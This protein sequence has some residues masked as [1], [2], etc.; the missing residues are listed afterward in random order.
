V[1]V[2]PNVKVS[3][4]H[5]IAIKHLYNHTKSHSGDFHSFYINE[6][7]LLTKEPSVLLLRN[8]KTSNYTS[9]TIDPGRQQHM[10]EEGRKLN[11]E[12]DGKQWCTL[13]ESWNDVTAV[14]VFQHFQELG[15]LLK[16]DGKYGKY[17]QEHNWTSPT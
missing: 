7:F 2:V 11:K 12:K 4:L 15:I 1:Q 14:T 13:T 8:N 10:V 3:E 16:G 6:E 17:I 9:T 5:Q